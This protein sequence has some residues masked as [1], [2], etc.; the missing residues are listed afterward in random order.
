[1]GVASASGAGNGPL[2]LNSGTFSVGG[3]NATGSGNVYYN[4]YTV[5]T[6]SVGTPG[7]SGSIAGVVYNNSAA[8]MFLNGY[9]VAT[10]A[11]SAYATLAGGLSLT[12]TAGATPVL[13]V[14]GS[15]I[16]INGLNDT[17]IGAADS[18]LNWQW[19]GYNAGQ[20]FLNLTGESYVNKTELESGLTVNLAGGTINQ[21]NGIFYFG[22]N[23]SGSM[24]M[25]GASFFNSNT[26]SLQIGYAASG[27]L[28]LYD[29]AT[30]A[31][32]GVAVYLGANNAGKGYIN[33][34][35]SAT[36]VQ[37]NS[38]DF[39]TSGNDFGVYN[40]NSGLLSVGT[41][42]INVYTGASGTV[43]FLGGSLSAMGNFTVAS[44]AT[45]PADSALAINFQQ[46]AIL[47]SLRPYDHLESTVDGSFRLARY[48]GRYGHLE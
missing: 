37:A 23:G 18:G 36:L 47:R 22:V 9:A 19:D 16:T 29:S 38:L 46:N 21:V 11:N 4:S 45:I 24:N 12:T 20:D 30:L 44:S 43:N 13:H 8:N 10:P 34:F 39:G 17:S 15:G 42:G 25:T 40:L 1:M 3:L 33:Q 5:G 32:A 31:Y 27:I 14:A 26:G 2:Y 35:G 7:Q 6:I 48:R 28:N 41:G